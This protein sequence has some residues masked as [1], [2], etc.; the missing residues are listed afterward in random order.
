MICNR[1]FFRKKLISV[2]LIIDP[3][4]IINAEDA[5]SAEIKFR[6]MIIGTHMRVSVCLFYKNDIPDHFCRRPHIGKDL[7]FILFFQYIYFRLFVCCFPGSYFFKDMHFILVFDDAVLLDVITKIGPDQFFPLR[8]ILQC[9][10]FVRAPEFIC[11]RPVLI[12]C[13]D[14]ISS[15]DELQRRI[16][17]VHGFSH[18]NFLLVILCG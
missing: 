18:K 7:R 12:E 9:P 2:F 17:S 8:I 13:P 15:V 10:L 6:V 5:V 11:G 14:G 16:W 4:I 3:D 1:Q